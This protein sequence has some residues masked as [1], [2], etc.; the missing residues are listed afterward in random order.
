MKKIDEEYRNIMD[1]A[2]EYLYNQKDESSCVTSTVQSRRWGWCSKE[3][4][5]NRKKFKQKQEELE[6]QP[7]EL[8]EKCKMEIQVPNDK[9]AREGEK[10]KLS[11]K[12][13]LHIP[14]AHSSSDPDSVK[15]E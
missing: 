5:R 3:H 8:K 12:E 15:S 7:T 1:Q 4:K 2:N 14:E 9:F 10:F 13:V 11:K 6:R